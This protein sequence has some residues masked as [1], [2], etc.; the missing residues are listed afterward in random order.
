MNFFDGGAEALRLLKVETE[1]IAELQSLA[2]E[3]EKV[4]V[5]REVFDGQHVLGYGA[6][7]GRF[8]EDP[9]WGQRINVAC[10]I[11]LALLERLPLRQDRCPALTGDF[12]ARL[13]DILMR[14]TGRDDLR[15][16]LAKVRSQR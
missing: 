11:A 13:E 15:A 12:I 4:F 3:I 8:L 16:R 10:E 2:D 7:L 1:Q 9:I 5:V 14:P 6:A